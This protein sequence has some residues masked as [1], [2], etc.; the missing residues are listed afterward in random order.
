MACA[1]TRKSSPTAEQARSMIE[2]SGSQQ[3][4]NTAK[5]RLS[6]G[7]RATRSSLDL[8]STTVAGAVVRRAWFRR[9]NES[10][11]DGRRPE[12]EREAR[13]ARVQGWD[14]LMS[15]RLAK[16]AHARVRARVPSPLKL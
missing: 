5:W 1:K 11:F 3:Y 9:N 2:G 7:M 15:A 12:V 13:A 14:E 16:R 6:H 8:A 10:M 4:V